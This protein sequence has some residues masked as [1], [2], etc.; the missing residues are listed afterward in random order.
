MTIVYVLA[1]LLM[2]S[3]TDDEKAFPTAKPADVGN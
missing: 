2:C 1:V 3:P